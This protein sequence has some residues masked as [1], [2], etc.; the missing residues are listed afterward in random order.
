[1][2]GTLKRQL[3]KMQEQMRSRMLNVLGIREVV[4]MKHKFAL[5]VEHAMRARAASL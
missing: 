1:M 5:E 2:T 4:A 3:G